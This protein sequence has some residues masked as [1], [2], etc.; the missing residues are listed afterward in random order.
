M[1]DLSTVEDVVVE[2]NQTD[3]DDMKQ[4]AIRYGAHA[5]LTKGA[6]RCLSLKN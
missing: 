2:A 3:G 5:Q 1:T 4:V 6:I